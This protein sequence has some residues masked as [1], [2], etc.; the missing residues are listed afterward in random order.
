MGLRF[1]PLIGVLLWPWSWLA[2]PF[3]AGFARVCDAIVAPVSGEGAQI[4]FAVPDSD[5]KHPWWILMSVKNIFTGELFSIPVDTRTLAYVRIAVFVALALTWPVAVTRR[6]AGAL[7]VGIALFAMAMALSVGL[8][9]LQVLGIVRVVGLGVLSQSVI[10][11]GILTF[12][13]YPSMA[14]AIPALI[15]WLTWRMALPRSGG[16]LQGVPASEKP[17]LAP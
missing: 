4:H 12:V 11:I 1:V 9:L 13:T 6:G 15:W 2:R 3:A 7:A 10:S 16:A 14:Y 8:P 17:A 5:P